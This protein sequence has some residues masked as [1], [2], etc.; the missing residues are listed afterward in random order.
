MAQETKQEPRTPTVLDRRKVR[1][2]LSR[3]FDFYVAF[4]VTFIGGY[5]FLDPQWPESLGNPQYWIITIEDIYLCLSG[6]VIMTALIARTL[7]YRVYL[8]MV[9][10][11]FGWLFVSAAAVVIV[12]SSP[13]V[14][15]V[16]VQLPNEDL[17]TAWVLI[18]ALLAAAAAVRY[19]NIRNLLR[20][21]A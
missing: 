9:A 20:G 2:I 17:Q 4:L 15:P 7:N 8:S 16:A 14:P 19:A 11:M 5:G 10:E 6:V 1:G 3:P 13:W 18:W 21:K 12:V